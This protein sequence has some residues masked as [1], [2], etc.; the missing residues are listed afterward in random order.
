MA[1]ITRRSEA[2]QAAGGRMIGMAA[3]V[4]RQAGTAAGGRNGG[5]ALSEAAF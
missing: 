2:G 4:R 3:F 1:D 5:I